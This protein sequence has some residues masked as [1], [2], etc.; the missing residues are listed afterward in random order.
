[1]ETQRRLNL[2]TI[3]SKNTLH[4]FDNLIDSLYAFDIQGKENLTQLKEIQGN[5]KRSEWGR[6]LPMIVL[7]N[8]V[9]ADDPLILVAVLRK[10]LQEDLGGL[11]IP[12]SEDY[13][14][15]KNFPAYALL[16]KLANQIDG[17]E[18]IPIT[19][20]YRLRDQRLTPKELEILTG[21]ADLES[22]RFTRKLMKDFPL[23]KVLLL[24][25]EGHRSPDGS[26][27]PA[28]KGLGFAVSLAGNL[29]DHKKI[30]EALVLS[31]GLTYPPGYS[32]INAKLLGE[33]KLIT[34][35]VGPI[36][37]SYEAINNK[38][39]FAKEF[40]LPLRQD[41]SAEL[42]TH[43]LMYS[44]SLLLPQS[45]RGVYDPGHS[46]FSQVLKNEVKQGIGKDGKWGIF[47]FSASHKIG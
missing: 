37:T 17:L 16:I 43:S 13:S 29:I 5:W 23:G 15:F 18:M 47:D 19:Q 41:N 21:K 28:E 9:A 10:F 26:L 4:L 8:H 44:N 2:R 22:L 27:I 14:H 31:F 38:A 46:L 11:V 33:K 34:V 35:N 6:P 25:P 20:S 1:M 45:M 32:K 24:A 12:Y 42:I 7:F 40:N 39:D 3:A 36:I 30:P